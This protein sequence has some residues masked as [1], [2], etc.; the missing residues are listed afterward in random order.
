MSKSTTLDFTSWT[1]EQWRLF[2]ITS[3]SFLIDGLI[4]SISPLIIYSINTLVKYA[5]YILGINM[6]FWTLGSILLGRLGDIIGRKLTFLIVLILE[7]L[8][9]G[10][11]YIFYTNVIL[12]TFLTSLACF[13]I[14]GEFGAAFSAIAELT[15]PDHRGKAILL[16][17]NFWNLGAVIISSLSLLYKYFI[18]PILQIKYLLASTL[19]IVVLTGFARIG[20]P[21]SIR[22]LVIKGKIDDV[23]RI[24]LKYNIK[25]DD[26]ILNEYKIKH[27]V[28]IGKIFSKYSYRIAILLILTIAVYVTYFIPTFYLP[29]TPDFPFSY[30]TIPLIILI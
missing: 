25:L 16:A 4:F 1:S 2:I 23:K 24:L 11:L 6:I 28:S 20:F 10:L 22:W 12:F 29:Y 5:T 26:N 19:V 21:E 14:G 17:S 8:S 15:P 7:F 3:I 30:N 13:S 9:I 27:N 18:N